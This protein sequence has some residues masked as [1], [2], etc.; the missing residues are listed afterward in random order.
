LT[1]EAV[2]GTSLALECIDHVHSCHSLPFGVLSVSDSIADHVLQEDLQPSAGLFVDEARNTLDTAA[3]SQA[4]DGGLGDA[5]DVIA[6]HFTV[7]LGASFAEPFP[8]FA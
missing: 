8:A 4:T 7:A 3:P 1:A 2:Q 6:Q 5:L